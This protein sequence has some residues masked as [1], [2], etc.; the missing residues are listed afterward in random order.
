MMFTSFTS[1][2]AAKI[3]KLKSS[4]N[5]EINLRNLQSLHVDKNSSKKAEMPPVEK[6]DQIL[7]IDEKPPLTKFE[8]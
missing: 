7:Q 2:N 4:K 5:R 1:A 3:Q 8:K 6:L